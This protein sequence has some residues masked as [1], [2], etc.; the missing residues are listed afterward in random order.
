MR[1][2]DTK[3]DLRRRNRRR[4][5]KNGFLSESKMERVRFFS[6]TRAF[7]TASPNRR[8]KL[9]TRNRI[10]GTTEWPVAVREHFGPKATLTVLTVTGP[11]PSSTNIQ[12]RNDRGF[13]RFL[14][15]SPRS[16]PPPPLHTFAE[17]FVSSYVGPPYNLPGTLSSC[18]ILAAYYS[19]LSGLLGHFYYYERA[20]PNY[21]A[22]IDRPIV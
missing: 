17:T 12:Y 4:E 3:N 13:A 20:R 10:P 19:R 6:N 21:Q 16:L 5:S 15:A 14:K 2:D 22:P 9:S 7:G 18:P 11:S 1:S 8:R